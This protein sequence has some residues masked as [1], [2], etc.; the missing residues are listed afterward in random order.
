VDTIDVLPVEESLVRHDLHQLE[1][2]RVLRRLVP[3]QFVMNRAYRC[4]TAV[5]ENIQDAEFGIGRSGSLFSG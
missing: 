4:R 2:G 3:L 1:S 5:P